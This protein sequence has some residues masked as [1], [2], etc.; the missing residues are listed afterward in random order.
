MA[1]N[2]PNGSCLV[3]W[4]AGR[5]TKWGGMAWVIINL[6]LLTQFAVFAVVSPSTRYCGPS[7][8]DLRPALVPAPTSVASPLDSQWTSTYACLAATQQRGGACRIDS[9]SASFAVSFLSLL[10]LVL[11]PLLSFVPIVLNPALQSKK[12]AI[13]LVKY[14]GL[15]PHSRRRVRSP[16][17]RTLP[18]LI[19]PSRSRRRC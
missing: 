2:L 8:H 11:P 4:H 18:V 15:F 9:P 17:P 7:A 3:N 19:S 10:S 5:R 6:A 13:S 1:L 12:P 16:R 14:P